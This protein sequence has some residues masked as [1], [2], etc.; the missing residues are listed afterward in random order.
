MRMQD[1]RKMKLWG[2]SLPDGLTLGYFLGNPWCILLI[3]LSAWKVIRSSK[4]LV[5]RKI[6][7][8]M[9]SKSSKKFQACFMFGLLRT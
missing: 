2:N 5:Q 1:H 6:K 4:K 3:P 7:L 9:T 8:R